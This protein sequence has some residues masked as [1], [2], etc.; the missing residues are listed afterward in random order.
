MEPKP[1]VEIFTWLSVDKR[2]LP[3][4]DS[5]LIAIGFFE[6][7]VVW[8]VAAKPKNFKM[9]YP[10]EPADL[11]DTTVKNHLLGIA[12]KHKMTEVS[13]DLAITLGFETL[14]QLEGTVR[15]QV[16]NKMVQDKEEQAWDMIRDFLFSQVR[17]SP[18]PESWRQYKAQEAYQESVKRFKNE[19]AFLKAVGGRSRADII[20]HYSSQMAASLAEQLAFRSWANGI[21]EG[22]SDLPNIF[23]YFNAV[24]KHVLK[25]MEIEENA[26]PDAT[27]KAEGIY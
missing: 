1:T 13:E 18:I 9:I 17:I 12:A 23:T 5:A 26:A 4:G 21:V 19:E 22:E 20:R 25:N 24:K 8:Q 15:K 7:E 6:P 14:A 27:V 2:D 11:L 10:V 16:E 3:N